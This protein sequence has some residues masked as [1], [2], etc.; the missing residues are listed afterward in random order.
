VAS[1]AASSRRLVRHRSGFVAGAV[2][3][4]RD[5]HALARKKA[6]RRDAAAALRVAAV[7]PQVLRLLRGP[8]GRDREPRDR[9]HGRGVPHKKRTKYSGYLIT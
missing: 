6:G 7:G 9:V 3:R 4:R 8:A 5:T 2:S 1:T